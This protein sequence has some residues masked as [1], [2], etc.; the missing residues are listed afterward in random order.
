MATIPRE[1][2]ELEPDELADLN[3]RWDPL[4]GDRMTELV[5]IG[6]DMDHD[7]IIAKLDSCVLTGEEI[8][9]GLSGWTDLDDPLPVWEDADDE[10][11]TS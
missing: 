2:W 7:S 10:Y 8:E 5:F 11:E 1:Q 9:L 6:I 3:N 4:L